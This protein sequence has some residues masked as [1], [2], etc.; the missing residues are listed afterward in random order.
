MIDIHSH[1]LPGIDDGSKSLEEA[2][3]LC[4]LAAGDG[5]R[6]LVCTPHINFRYEN[7]RE[8]IEAPF[9]EL[10]QAIRQAGVDLNLIRG[11][12]VHM[13]PEIITKLK[14]GEL[15]TYDDAGRYLL[16]E[17]PFQQVITGAEDMV[18]RL[19]LAGV[20]PV[21]AHPERIAYFMDDT[22]RLFQLVRLGAL[23][24]VTGASVLGQFGERSQRAVMR[25]VAR[26]LAHI[27]ASDAHDRL[28]RPPALS[29]AAGA[30]ARLH[31][32]ERVRAMFVDYPGA[33]VAGE[34]IEPPAPEEA[35]SKM[36]GLLQ[37]LVRRRS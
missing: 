5:T 17:F 30:I 14:Q 4:R 34:E 16:L 3:E 35:T 7:R 32:E 9:V 2:V 1:V 29:E 28:H 21:I 24:Q 25:M 37:R 11:A 20:T 10:S 23:G 27:V 26:G 19:R 13:A 31:G 33:I 15:V 22:E 6:T 36:G 8:T 18:Y 12:E